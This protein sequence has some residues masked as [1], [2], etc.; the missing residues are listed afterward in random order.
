MMTTYQQERLVLNGGTNAPEPMSTPEESE[1][2]PPAPGTEDPP[3][4]I[5]KLDNG[6]QKASLTY[7]LKQI[8]EVVTGN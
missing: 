8:G 4:K 6:S 2:E 1:P 7:D 3:P 5:P